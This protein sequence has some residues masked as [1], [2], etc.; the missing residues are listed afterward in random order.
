MNMI[1]SHVIELIRFSILEYF[2]SFEADGPMQSFSKTYFILTDE[3]IAIF[4]GHNRH[5][6]Q[7]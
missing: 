3:D 4:I 5:H 7:I 6:S 2:L 1:P